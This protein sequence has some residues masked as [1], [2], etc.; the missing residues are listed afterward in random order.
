MLLP[1]SRFGGGFRSEIMQNGIDRHYTSPLT[2]REVILVYN[3]KASMIC[4]TYANQIVILAI[5][6]PTWPAFFF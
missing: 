6:M 5:G 1:N 2:F 4:K 3:R